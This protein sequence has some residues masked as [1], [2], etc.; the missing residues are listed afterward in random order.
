MIPILYNATDT[1]FSTYGVGTLR[2]TLSCQVT[3]ERNGAYEC[4]LTYPVTGH[5]YAEIQKE[6][7]IKAIL[8]FVSILQRG[9]NL[10][11]R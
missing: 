2:D 6:R 5:L 3:E 7:L 1:D 4:V 9:L 8:P 11:V 10:L